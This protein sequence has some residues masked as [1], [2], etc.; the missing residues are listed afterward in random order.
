M[1]FRGLDCTLKRSDLSSSERMIQMRDNIR[2]SA[3]AAITAAAILLT[4]L[5]A[6]AHHPF[7]S[8]FDW[9]KPVTLAGTVTNVNWANP[10]ATIALEF[11]DRAGTVTDWLVELGSPTVLEKNYQ[12]TANVVRAGDTVTVD[13]WLAK[14]GQKFVNAKSVRLSDGRELFAASSFFDLPGRCVSEEVCVED[15]PSSFSD[16]SRSQ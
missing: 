5:P 8:E 7:A 10:H 6:L 1:Q 13:G 9:K 3:A 11:R 4:G 14:D 15:A 12:W 16:P 2:N